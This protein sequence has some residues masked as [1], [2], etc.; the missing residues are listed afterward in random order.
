LNSLF[1]VALHLPSYQV[2]EA[3]HAHT[4]LDASLAEVK[5]ALES[6]CLTLA[7]MCLTDMGVSNTDGGVS[8]TDGGVSDTAQVKEAKHAHKVLEA[9]L[10]M[11]RYIILYIYIFIYIYIYTYIYTYI[12][13]YIYIYAGPVLDAGPL[14]AQVKEAKHA[15][16]VLEASLAEVK[17]KTLNSN[18]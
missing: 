12:Y 13:I 6:V 15:H 2:K 10:T 7:P 16:K 18:L 8:N 5:T 4:V 1:Q 11:H 17:P 14:T 9:S 3:K